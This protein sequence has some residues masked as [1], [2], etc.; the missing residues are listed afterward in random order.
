MARRQVAIVGAGPIGLEAAVLARSRDMDVTVL[1]RGRIAENVR[2][3]GHVQLFSPF[4]MNA[5]LWGR[6]A[7]AET[8]LPDGKTFLTGSEF[9]E[10]YLLPLSRHA[11]LAGCIRETSEVRGI[12]RANLWKGDQIGK[13]SRVES[14]FRLLIRSDAG[15]ETTHE[16]DVVLDCTGTY[17]NHN[18]LGAGGLP[19]PG[20]TAA[21]DRIDYELR[22]VSGLDRH[23]YADQTIL[24]AGG[25]YSAATAIVALAEL[26]K[27]ATNTRA[28]WLTRT[29]RTPP[30]LDLEDDPLPERARLTRAA[31]AIASEQTAAVRWLPDAT[32][33][34]LTST[35]QPRLRID[36]RIAAGAIET[37]ECDR[38]I[39]LVGYRPDRTLYEELQVHECY[40]TQGPIR[41][42]A[43]LLG[44]TSTD[45]LAQSEPGIDALRNPEP[46]FFILGS[47]SY[48]RDSRFLLR[49]GLSQVETVI[50]TISSEAP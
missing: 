11:L 6:K 3:W 45:C 38:V 21:S 36:I 42:A 15:D 24:V 46:G 22:D 26:S 1:E 49:T 29:A 35:D 44:E 39:A 16:A 19:A 8:Q 4:E 5:S 14:P 40:A 2:S 33:Q 30:L 23:R 20:E 32:V 7:L 17:G 31:N 28:I 12:S 37:L 13:P 47:K 48:G 41:L 9:F 27:Q 25:G 34:S 50:D 10:R 18:W 43:A